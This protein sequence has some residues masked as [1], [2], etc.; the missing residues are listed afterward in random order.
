MWKG[1][2]G[3]PCF[4]P[5]LTV[6]TEKKR[7]RGGSN[8]G[9]HAELKCFPTE[10]GYIQI[11]NQLFLRGKCILKDGI[12]LCGDG[13]FYVDNDVLRLLVKKQFLFLCH[14]PA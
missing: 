4:T 5:V 8:T 13:K 6:P 11:C 10:F 2:A 7:R 12:L 3:W 14:H 9:K 1:P